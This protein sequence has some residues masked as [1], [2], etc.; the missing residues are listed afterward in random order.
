M[1]SACGSPTAINFKCPVVPT[2]LITKMIKFFCGMSRC[3]VLL[4]GKQLHD[5]CQLYI[6]NVPT[7]KNIYSIGASTNL[8]AIYSYKG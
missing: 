7:L 4:L 8:T 6:K 1:V 5:I 3:R 2:I